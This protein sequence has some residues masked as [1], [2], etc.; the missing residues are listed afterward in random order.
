MTRRAWGELL[1]LS[2]LWGAVYLLIEIT[3]RELSPVVVVLGRVATAA[4]MLTPLALR[5][6][7]LQPLLQHP[8]VVLQTVLVQSTIPLVLL[9]VGQQY[10]SSGTA[11]ILIGAQPLV[12][13][14]LTIRFAVDERPHGWPGILG[15]LLGL[16][17][18]LLLFGV[19]LRGG[20]L[21]LFGGLLVL[22][23][24]VCYAAGAVM[25]HRRLAHA[26][27]LGVATSSMLVT[28]AVLLVPGLYALPTDTPSLPVIGA[29]LILGVVCTG[30][31]L[32]LFYALISKA[33]PSRAALAFYLSPAFA[34]G[35]GGVLLG[36]PISAPQ[37]AGLT[38]ILI[39]AA[40]AGRS[41]RESAV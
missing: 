38:A 28:T 13:A 7:A 23:A 10:V 2:V 27:P 6:G 9:T 20:G 5:Y 31:T 22:G 34:V 17:G 16:V 3:L 32:V 19:D 35:F 15:I 18:L 12:V 4:A 29:L 26:A 1:L 24:A 30:G 40:L 25:I 36:E 8:R 14:I 21:E 39:G 33:G 41:Q 11:G 37:I